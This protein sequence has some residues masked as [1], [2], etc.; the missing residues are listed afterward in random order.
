VT[1]EQARAG[2]RKGQ[3]QRIARRRTRAPAR[4]IVAPLGTR[5]R[6]QRRRAVARAV[7]PPAAAEPSG[8]ST[9]QPGGTDWWS[10]LERAVGLLATMATLAVAAFT[11]VSISQV[12]DEQRITREGQITDRYNDAIKNLGDASVDVR[13]GGIYALQRIMKD[14][15]R[16]QPSVLSVLSAYVRVHASA[17]KGDGSASGKP[18]DDV[19]AALTVLGHRNPGNDGT[20]QVDLAGA[21]LS[22]VRLHRA[23]LD[24]ADL[25]G[26]DLSGAHLQSVGLAGADLHDADLR[27][28]DLGGG[29]NV[30][31]TLPRGLAARALGPVRSGAADLRWAD[32]RGA[33]L[34]DADLTGARMDGASLSDA[35]LGGVSLAGTDLSNMD[36]SHRDLRE[37]D[38]SGTDLQG[39]DLTD[40]D[41]RAADL[42]SARV[43]AGQVLSA[44][45]IDRDTE[46]SSRLRKDPEIRS[47][48]RCGGP[49]SGG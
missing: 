26:A 17:A 4:R 15:T 2:A 8:G 6:G 31:G 5:Q 10:R 18:S 25:S 28:A 24:D 23:H 35:R 29:L 45:A 38:L 13:Y 1:R 47:A 37:A 12:S 9:D 16:D 3:L 36:L 21:R 39:A 49:C 44:A 34:R 27:G 11:W 22:D 33:D 7:G 40:A 20:G 32:L 48:I 19:V 14:S 42:R 46:L 41:L 43:G 30:V